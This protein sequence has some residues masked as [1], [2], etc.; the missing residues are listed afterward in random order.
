MIIRSTR[1]TVDVVFHWEEVDEVDKVDEVN[2]VGE[3][4][5]VTSQ[6]EARGR[7]IYC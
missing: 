2:E 1:R 7:R 3:L 4:H 5:F 6:E